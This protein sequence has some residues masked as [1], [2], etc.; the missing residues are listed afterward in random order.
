MV[1]TY[2]AGQPAIRGESAGRFISRRNTVRPLTP[3]AQVLPFLRT[4]RAYLLDALP[5][6]CFSDR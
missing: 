6:K 2:W 3:T 1:A 5:Q 4:S